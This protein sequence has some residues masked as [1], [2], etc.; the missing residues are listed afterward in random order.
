MARIPTALE[1]GIGSVDLSGLP[2]PSTP[3]QSLNAPVEA[4]GGGRANNLNQLSLSTESLAQEGWKQRQEADAIEAADLDSKAQREVLNLLYDGENGIFAQKGGLALGAT[5]VA[6]K[7]VQDLKQKY[8]TQASSE[9]VRKI[10]FK[11][12]SGLENSTVE[13]TKRHEFK[14]GQDY[15]AEI[16]GSRQQLNAEAVALNWNDDNEFDKRWEDQKSAVLAEGKIKGL[17][18]DALNLR[19][20]DARSKMLGAR[21]ISMLETDDEKNII[22]AGRLYDEARNSGQINFEETQKLDRMLDAVRPKAV[23]K[24]ALNELKA[25]PDI[26]TLDKGQI[27]DNGIIGVES[28]GRQ[29]DKDGKPL[30]SSAGAIGAAQVMPDTAKWVA[31][32]LLKQPFDDVRYKNYPEYNKALGKTYF[33]HLN[34]KYNNT[35]LAVLAYNWGDGNLDQYIEK[36][37]DP[38]TGEVPMSKFLAMVPSSEARNY[39]PKVMKSLGLTSGKI[40][41]DI[42]EMR[43]SELDLEVA[44]SGD[45]LR[46]LVNNHNKTIEMGE[47]EYALNVKSQL[48]AK[49]AQAN[50]DWTTLSAWERAEAQRVG[51][52]DDVTKF[53]GVS[54]PQVVLHL[55]DMDPE[56]LAR[57]DIREYAGRLSVTDLESWGKKIQEVRSK[58]ENR[59]EYRTKQQLIKDYM[60]AFN[61]K[62]ENALQFQNRIEDAAGAYQAKSGKPPSRDDLKTILDT[63]V[64]DPDGFGSAV[65]KK[66]KTEQYDVE[67]VP[68][69]QVFAATSALRG[70]GYEINNDNLK[71]FK[72]DP[73]KFI[74]IQGVDK[75]QINNA[76]GVLIGRGYS[77]NRDFV[78]KLIRAYNKGGAS[79]SWEDASNGNW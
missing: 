74:N 60:K 67:G 2:S 41:Q 30:T 19:L 54:E 21:I 28:N 42:A 26:S 4:F 75:E 65:Y 47:K 18:P 20:S 33:E 62:D 50:G 59:G 53:K 37:G 1:S 79:A 36:V 76:V 58:P 51:V 29:F 43:A 64:L 6:T 55:T 61:I 15:K 70:L 73:S 24:N 8:L 9:N 57:V 16:I 77:V 56:D 38:R 39:V 63:L 45:E 31:E 17:S 46:E 78:L 66:A 12:L 44:G 11:S 34:T 22:R 52:W 69:I 49:V 23:A 27:F 13:A 35:T 71:S 3:R 5:E 32:S 25:V 48:S 68:Q 10:L 72:E 7:R 40:S 14:E